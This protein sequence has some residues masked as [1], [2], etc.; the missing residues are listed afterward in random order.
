MYSVFTI[1]Y[2]NGVM[3]KCHVICTSS[4]RACQDNHQKI[5]INKNAA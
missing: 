2:N 5:K 1:T 4:Y 3:V